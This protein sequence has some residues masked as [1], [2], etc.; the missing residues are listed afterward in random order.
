MNRPKL[1]KA[2]TD[3]GYILWLSRFLKIPEELAAIVY[4]TNPSQITTDE[5]RRQYPEYF[6]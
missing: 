3:Y 1:D 4:K 2:L 5:I 6:I